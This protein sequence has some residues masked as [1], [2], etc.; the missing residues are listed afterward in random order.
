MQLPI[1]S[2]KFIPPQLTSDTVPRREIL[3]QLSG[4]RANCKLVVF[5][6]PAGYGKT[7]AMLQYYQQLQ[8]TDCALVWVTLDDADNDI[9]RY[10]HC[11][12]RAFSEISGSVEPSFENSSAHLGWLVEM[13]EQ[14]PKPTY[15]F[16][17]DFETIYEPGLIGMLN[18]G[19]SQ[20]PPDKHVVIGTRNP[21]ELSISRMLVS[22][23]AIIF[24]PNRL[25]FQKSEADTFIDRRWL[26]E[27][28]STTREIL[29]QATE[30]WPAAMQ[31][32]AMAFGNAQVSSESLAS[33]LQRSPL[34]SNYVI[35]NVLRT[36][37]TE[38]ANFL[39]QTSCLR[40]LSASLCN[41]LTGQNNG[42]QM[43]DEISVKGMF[44]QPIDPDRHWF[45]H[46]KLFADLLRQELKKIRP[47]EYET[48][49]RQAA[50]WLEAD[51][52]EAAI[53]YAFE[54][55]D[56][57]LAGKIME[58]NI[59]ALLFDGRL[60]TINRWIQRLRD[61]DHGQFPNILLSAGWAAIFCREHDNAL[62]IIE[63]LESVPESAHLN[64]PLGH[65]L[66]VVKAAYLLLQDD[67]QQLCN[68]DPQLVQTIEQSNC[69]NRLSIVNIHALC[70]LVRGETLQCS[71][72][73]KGRY[74]DRQQSNNLFSEIY[75]DC[76]L[77]LTHLIQGQLDLTLH[78]LDI[79]KIDRGADPSSRNVPLAAI[80]PV[81]AL[82]L[83]EKNAIDDTIGLLENNLPIIRQYGALD[84]EAMAFTTLSRCYYLKG[85]LAQAT[86]LLE[87]LE[88][89][90][91]AEN[92]PRLIAI[93]RWEQVRLATLSGQYLQAEQIRQSIL[94]EGLADKDWPIL[95]PPSEMEHNG[96]SSYRLAIH[97][98]QTEGLLPQ[99]QREIEQADSHQRLNR[100]LKLQ[101]LHCLTEHRCDNLAQALESLRLLLQ[102]FVPAG[103]V[104][105][106][107]DEG[108]QLI[109][110]LKLID[111]ESTPTSQYARTLLAGCSDEQLR[112]IPT[113]NLPNKPI[114]KQRNPQ[115]ANPLIEPLTG[116]EQQI[117][118]LVSLGKANREIAN[119]LYVSEATIKWHLGNI[120]TK[121]GV[122]QRT[123]AIVRARELRLLP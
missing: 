94:D 100:S 111:A 67:L 46:H 3:E 24:D 50:R 39:L 108:E 70:L 78:A 65:S 74:R 112:M 75:Y 40:L 1:S 25:R 76:M 55:G 116:R 122:K 123:P 45:V 92:W 17:D 87:E 43:L 23:E 42:Q 16:L 88:R 35:E 64:L 118:T 121:L 27:L 37:T 89:S 18:R 98:N 33:T 52:P 54:A 115:Q 30:G 56:P 7:T 69:F 32:G 120:Y 47:G 77:G 99:L 68:L 62:D 13:I 21:P 97:Q 101:L 51:R 53:D 58:N 48:L 103:F 81:R 31:L 9:V 4:N 59:Q 73:L 22:G 20:L 107:L 114:P 91:Y 38:T 5:Q 28:T 19:I 61:I 26:T 96:L 86:T 66:A 119:E 57:Q 83:Y 34:V 106:F 6:A 117:L 80:A 11:L 102:Q 10:F 49:C 95:L 29:Y 14:I 84:W 90:G 104:R 109:Q 71:R 93:A 36:L 105:S 110:L 60:G 79:S 82:I 12:A 72:W 63:S 113:Q 2:N 8:Q 41:A 44:I 85:D 15:I